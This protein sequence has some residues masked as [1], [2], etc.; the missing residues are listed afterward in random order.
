MEFKW[1]SKLDFMDFLCILIRIKNN[2]TS[3]FYFHK[4]KASVNIFCFTQLL[5]IFAL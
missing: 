3:L 4:C 5:L 1:E 2:K